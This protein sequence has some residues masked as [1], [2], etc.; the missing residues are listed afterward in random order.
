MKK[1][2]D[3]LLVSII[4]IS[5]NSKKAIQKCLDSVLNQTYP[6]IEIIVVDSSDDGTE[7][8][9][10]GYK[11]KSKFPFKIIYQ[12]PGGVGVARNTGIKASKG[13]AIQFVDADC[14]IPPGY[15]ETVTK[16]LQSS[17]KILGVY[18]DYKPVPSSNS[19]FSKLIN[20]YDTLSHKY[21]VL[22]T[23]LGGVDKFIFRREV[24][25]RIGMYNPKLK[26]G[27][28][29]E[30]FN[31]LMEFKNDVEKKGYKFEYTDAV[32]FYEEKQEQT[33]KEYYKK[34]IWYGLPLLNREYF[35]SNSV[36]N[37]LKIVGVLYFISFPYFIP[38]AVLFNLNELILIYIPIMVCAV[39]YFFY[40]ALK[41]KYISWMIILF[42]VLLIYKAHGLFIGIAKS[43][44]NSL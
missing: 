13:D 17:E 28:D 14:Y 21:G 33:F 1:Q 35:K 7:R 34:C 32:T 8:I 5:R 20:I 30:F 15:I 19:F 11:E 44:I 6:L 9:I 37:I 43:I 29:A 40:K 23:N 12:E 3:G 39:L 38:I 22:N 26:V 25:E 4:I 27:E 18:T 2:L 36:N 41:V 31:R 16:L 42:P 24:Y 10:E